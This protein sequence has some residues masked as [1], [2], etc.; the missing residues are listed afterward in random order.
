MRVKEKLTH[1]DGKTRSDVEKQA[2]EED[3]Y[4]VRLMEDTIQRVKAGVAQPA[5][6]K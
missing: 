3:Q 2:G 4:I 5:Q 6:P 1:L